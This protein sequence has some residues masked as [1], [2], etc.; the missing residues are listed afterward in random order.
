[1][2][3]SRGS[4]AIDRAVEEMRVQFTQLQEETQRRREE[5][6]ERAQKREAEM[7]DLIVTTIISQLK[8]VKDQ[9]SQA[10]NQEVDERLTRFETRYE[11][12]VRENRGKGIG[13][14][15]AEDPTHLSMSV[16]RAD[17]RGNLSGQTNREMKNWREI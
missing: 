7:Q 16:L 12:F 6:A 3:G 4:N 9:V 5:E 11:K 15:E 10:V 14:E 1:M 8:S 17:R 2:P 13:D